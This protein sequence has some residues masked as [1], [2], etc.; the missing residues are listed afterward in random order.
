M[1]FKNK[2]NCIVTK[3]TSLLLSLVSLAF[4]P[5]SVIVNGVE[6]TLINVLIL[7]FISGMFFMVG[8]G[9]LL[10]TNNPAYRWNIFTVDPSW[11]G[12]MDKSF[13]EEPGQIFDF[14]KPTK[15]QLRDKKIKEVLR[16][17]KSQRA[18]K[19]NRKA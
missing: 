4:G 12:K 1:T 3:I 18:K 5:F 10:K 15:D 7:V 17:D 14:N 13:E 11:V 8:F 16:G 9:L 19:A 6:P 2:V